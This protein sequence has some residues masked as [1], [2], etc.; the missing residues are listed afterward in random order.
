ML[1]NA[2]LSGAA[3]TSLVVALFFLR[4]W[5][6]TLGHLTV[7]AWSRGAVTSSDASAFKGL[8]WCR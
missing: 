4:F 6:S 1:V 3:C 7:I 2:I 5:R 8:N